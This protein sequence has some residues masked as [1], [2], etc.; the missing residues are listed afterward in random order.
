M[1]KQNNRLKEDEKI[2]DFGSF[3]GIKRGFVYMPYT[4][5]RIKRILKADFEVELVWCNG[6]YKC[7][8]SPYYVRRYR[9]QDI[10]TGKT[11][12][13]DV[14][15][16]QIR[17]FLARHD[18]PLFDAKSVANSSKNKRNMNAV[19]FLRAVANAEKKKH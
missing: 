8:R 4:V 2:L 5:P 13:E 15:M 16:E 14:T 9:L 11:I 6:G 17:G 10:N 19:R 7:D 3:I 18:Y 1:E 12:C